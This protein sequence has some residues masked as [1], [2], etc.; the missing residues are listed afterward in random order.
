MRERER[1]RE[2]VCVLALV[3]E[4]RGGW[5]GG[6]GGRMGVE[7]KRFYDV[8]DQKLVCGEGTRLQI[9]FVQ[10]DFHAAWQKKKKKNNNNNKKTKRKESCEYLKGCGLRLNLKRKP[11][12]FFLK[13]TNCSFC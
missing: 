6:G 13:L 7:C 4:R 9:L 2:S 8:R 1:M 5:G 10:M 3:R 11:D 12:C